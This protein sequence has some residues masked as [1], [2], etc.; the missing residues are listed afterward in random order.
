MRQTVTAR[1]STPSGAVAG[2]SGSRNDVGEP[3]RRGRALPGR[4]VG[5]QPQPQPQLV[6]SSSSACV[7]Q[8][9]QP[10]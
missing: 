3:Q 8:H 9:V 1:S 10:H 6:F 7:L 5:D 4:V 2:P